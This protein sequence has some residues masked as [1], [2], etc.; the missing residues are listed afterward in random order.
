MIKKCTCYS[1]TFSFTS[2]GTEA[3]QRSHYWPFES[4]ITAARLYNIGNSFFGGDRSSSPLARMKL[5]DY[6][7]NREPLRIRGSVILM[8]CKCQ[9]TAPTTHRT[10]VRT[11]AFCVRAHMHHVISYTYIGA[12][13]NT[14]RT[15]SE[16][17]RE[18]WVRGAWFLCRPPLNFSLW[19][20]SELRFGG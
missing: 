19:L 8:A 14:A 20:M 18:S 13:A 17:K 1:S 15:T 16:R 12:H 6:C 9:G 5:E 2:A 4:Y 11:K 10:S 7:P 3:E